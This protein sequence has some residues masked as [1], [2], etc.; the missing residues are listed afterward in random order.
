MHKPIRAIFYG[1]TVLNSIS[2]LVCLLLPGRFIGM[3]TAEPA[4]AIAE[5]FIRWYGVLLI[6]ITYIMFRA[7][8]NGSYEV[9]KPVVQGYLIGD[10]LHLGVTWMLVDAAGSWSLGAWGSI[11]LTVLLGAVRVYALLVRPDL[12]SQV[13][14]ASWSTRLKR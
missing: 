14:P 11:I 7:L 4:G 2:A 5:A 8:R 1:E 12:M 9:L 6:V 10:V 3:F 13:H